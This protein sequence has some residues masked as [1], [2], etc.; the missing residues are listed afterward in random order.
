MAFVFQKIITGGQLPGL[1]PGQLVGKPHRLIPAHA[2]DGAV[3][4]P[5]APGGKGPDDCAPLGDGDL[6]A[7]DEEG[8]LQSDGVGGSLVVGC[9]RIV[10]AAGVVTSGDVDPGVVR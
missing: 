1:L 4:A 6:G 9:A 8:C 2:L 7:R 10:G 5:D 3:I